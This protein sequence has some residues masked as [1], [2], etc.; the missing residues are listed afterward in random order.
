MVERILND[1]EKKLAERLKREA[2][3]ARPEFSEVLHARICE[4]LKQCE[5]PVSQR[6]VTWWLRSGWLPVAIA[7]A[8]LVGVSLVA[9]WLGRPAG[10]GAELP[11][12][13]V[14]PVESPDPVA[15]PT[16]ITGP[17]ARTAE[18]VG[19]LVDSTVSAGQWA[20]LDH[21]ARVAF[22]LLMD[23]VPWDVASME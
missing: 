22:R 6:P 14:A 3:A 2:Q 20:Y 4:A 15:D 21:D 18:H 10:P 17:T 7:A 13:V 5:P 9:W 16:M 8:L 23:Q 1:E 19:T 12:M 11:E